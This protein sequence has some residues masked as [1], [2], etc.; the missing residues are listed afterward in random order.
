MS[1]LP[2]LEALHLVGLE[3]AAVGVDVQC[4]LRPLEY[5]NR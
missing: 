3:G 1:Q 4:A 5:L 2:Y